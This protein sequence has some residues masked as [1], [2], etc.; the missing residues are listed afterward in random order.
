LVVRSDK[1]GS[2]RNMTTRLVHAHK[3]QLT[4][5][6]SNHDAA[7]PIDYKRISIDSVI[8]YVKYR[9]KRS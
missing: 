4:I 5:I 1:A 6:P 7:P 8:G 9:K 2:S 3:Y